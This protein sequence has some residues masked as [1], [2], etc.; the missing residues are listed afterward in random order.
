MRQRMLSALKSVFSSMGV[1]PTRSTVA[2]DLNAFIERVRPRQTD[3]E[4]I[5]LGPTGDGGYLVPNDLEGIEACFSPGVDT[6]SGF[7]KDCA[8]MGMRVFM[9]DHSV[10]TPAEN[11]ESFSFEKKFVGVTA[12]DQFMT[13]D[14][15]VQSALGPSDGDL[16]VQIDI[17]GFEYEV[18]LAMSDELMRRF[19]IIVAEFHD[20]HLLRSQPFFR[21]ASRSF[22]KILQ[23]HV[24]VHIHP[25]NRCGSERIGQLEIP[26]VAEFTFLRK[27][28]VVQSEYANEFPHRLDSDN[29]VGESLVL[30]ACW[31]KGE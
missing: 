5:R 7:E 28:R 2:A 10:E 16:L 3:K 8:E 17:E 13:L 19:R 23:T 25:N 20:L 24:C 22:D 30:P 27:D 1:Y 31:Y 21:I 6:V 18:F 29:V 15:W 26:R 14:A 9:A 4:L 11:H 12:N